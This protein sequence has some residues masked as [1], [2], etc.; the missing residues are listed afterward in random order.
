M[1]KEVGIP[2]CNTPGSNRIW[3]KIELVEFDVVEESNLRRQA[4]NS[5]A[6]IGQSKLK[7]A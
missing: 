4:M 6:N 2:T 1:V 3:E 7:S 5:T